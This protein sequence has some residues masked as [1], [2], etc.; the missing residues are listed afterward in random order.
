MK[1]KGG[2]FF[3]FRSG[4]D[5]DPLSPIRIQIKMIRIHNTACKAYNLI[6]RMSIF[7]AYL[8][9]DINCDPI[10]IYKLLFLI[11]KLLN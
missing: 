8:T 10:L 2:I 1:K 7:I 9:L 3:D 5:P 6:N 11:S 4:S